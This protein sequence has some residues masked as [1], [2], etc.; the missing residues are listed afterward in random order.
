MGNLTAYLQKAFAERCP[1]EL[2]NLFGYSSRAD[3]LLAK[4]DGSRRLWIEFEVSRADPVANHAK[5]ATAHLFSRQL[6]SDCFISMVSSHVPRGRRNLAANTIYVMREA[7]MNAFQT[8]LLPEFAPDQIKRLNHLKVEEI[9]R[10]LLPVN[11]EIERAVSVSESVLATRE[12][13]IYF[14]ANLLEVMLN[15]RR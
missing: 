14:A 12:K 13:R 9:Q 2:N 4:N 1:E 11:R 8:F 10:E 6:E 3:V 15:L 7:G 5:F